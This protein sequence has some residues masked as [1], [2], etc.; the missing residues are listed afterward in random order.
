MRTV[1]E[2][3]YVV[4]GLETIWDASAKRFLLPAAKLERRCAPNLQRTGR[5]RVYVLHKRQNDALHTEHGDFSMHRG[6]GGAAH[7]WNIFKLMVVW[8]RAAWKTKNKY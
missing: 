4:T 2:T 7:S 3:P 8:W 6:N 5:R 1:R